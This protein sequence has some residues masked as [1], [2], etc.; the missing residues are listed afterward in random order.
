MYIE[1]VLRETEAFYKA[2]PQIKE[3]HGLSHAMVV[4]GHAVQAIACS[5]F[6]PLSTTTAT[7]TTAMMEIEVAALLHDVDDRK[8]F[9][10]QDKENNTKQEWTMTNKVTTMN[11]SENFQSNKA[12]EEALFNAKQICRKADIPIES[13]TRILT[14]IKWVGCSEN[15]NSV[16]T[17]VATTGLYHWLIPRWADRLEAVGSIGVVRCYQYTLEHDRPLWS[18]VSPRATTEEEVY[19]LATPDRFEAYVFS[20]RGGTSNDM[21]SHYYDKLLH[22]ARPSPDIVRNEYLERMAEDSA[23]DLVEVCIRFG[24]TGVVDKEYIQSLEQ[25]LKET[26]P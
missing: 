16:P 9:P 11:T 3:S 21:I 15:G 10:K 12:N 20:T 22:I 8:Y 2:N 5:A 7:T 4:H 26:K 19:R 17:E 23:R 1:R 24:Q 18:D 6:P 13:V 14:M 25:R